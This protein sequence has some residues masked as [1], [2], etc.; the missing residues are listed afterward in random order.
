[1]DHE[2][3]RLGRAVKQAQH[4]QHRAADTALQAIG[5]TLVQWDAMR[6]IAATPGASAHELAL[7]TFQTDQAFGTLANRLDAQALIDRRNGEGRRIEHR[8][9][10]KGEK[11]LA[12]GNAVTDRVRAELYAAITKADRR[13]L[14]EILERV[15]E[16]DPSS[17]DLPAA[18]AKGRP[19]AT[20]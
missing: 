3:E 15:L 19:K 1:M 10:A 2:L 13:R 8:L 12:A 9:T 11:L 5:T 7:A 14:A 17:L 4:R 6:A 18:K 20:P 16:G